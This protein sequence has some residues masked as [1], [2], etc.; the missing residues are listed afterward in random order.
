ML[1]Y[2]TIDISVIMQQLS[3]LSCS[4]AKTFPQIVRR[5]DF[6]FTFVTRACSP[7][8]KLSLLTKIDSF[9]KFNNPSTTA[10]SG[11]PGDC[12]PDFKITWVDSF[13]TPICFVETPRQAFGYRVHGVS[14]YAH[15]SLFRFLY[16]Q[17]K[18]SFVIISLPIRPL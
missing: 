12:V 11:N 15:F 7:Q 17:I 14:H 10:L 13:Y 2:N 18:L 8:I 3:Q 9:D 16:W 1:Q 6:F 5:R 4:A